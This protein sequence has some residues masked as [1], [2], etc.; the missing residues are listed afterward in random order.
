MDILEQMITF[1]K[2]DFRAQIFGES[3]LLY[4]ENGGSDKVGVKII[5]ISY[6]VPLNDPIAQRP[7]EIIE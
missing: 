4:K 6:I 1:F 7:H 5:D 2:H 3:L